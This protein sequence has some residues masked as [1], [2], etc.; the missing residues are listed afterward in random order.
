[1]EEKKFEKLNDQELD[2]VSGGW[3]G[4]MKFE[5]C[6]FCKQV[7]AR[8]YRD[9]FVNGEYVKELYCHNCEKYYYIDAN[10]NAVLLESPKPKQNQ[11]LFPD[12]VWF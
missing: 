12:P 9:I 7:L 10:G 1:M 2:Q 8:S 5:T 11:G 4:R 6:P 3:E